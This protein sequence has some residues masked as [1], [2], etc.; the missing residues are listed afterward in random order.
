MFEMYR[1]RVRF[2]IQNAEDSRKYTLKYRT[3]VT[4]PD[5]LRLQI[6]PLCHIARRCNFWT[7]RGLVRSNL[8]ALFFRL[9]NVTSNVGS[10]IKCR[11]MVVF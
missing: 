11:A 8:L 6:R 4:F 1:E 10:G 2:V 3:D 7:N 5:W 9:N